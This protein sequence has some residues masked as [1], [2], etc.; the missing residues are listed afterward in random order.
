MLQFQQDAAISAGNG[1]ADYE[2]IFSVFDEDNSHCLSRRELKRG[3]K[4][5]KVEISRDEFRAVCEHF[6]K[7]GDGDI[8]Y[9]EF[10]AFC[11]G[12]GGGASSPTRSKRTSKRADSEA[13]PADKE[14]SARE[15]R[16][17]ARKAAD[18]EASKA[19][20][21]R[22]ADRDAAKKRSMT[23][24]ERR[25]ADALSTAEVNELAQSVR[26][27]V[28]QAVRST[29]S[30][31]VDVFAKFDPEDKGYVTL[32]DLKSSL[33]E[34]GF[35][36]DK[37]TL[38]QLSL[39]FDKDGDGLVSIGEFYEFVSS[40]AHSSRRPTSR[41]TSGRSGI[42]EA[43]GAVDPTED[44]TGMGQAEVTKRLI[45]ELWREVRSRQ[46]S[47]KM[48]IDEAYRAL[49]LKGSGPR[50][51]TTASLKMNA[52]ELN[53]AIPSLEVAGRLVRKIG[54]RSYRDESSD[55]ADGKSED[56]F[57]VKESD[58][59]AF[60]NNPQ[61]KQ[62]EQQLRLAILQLVAVDSGKSAAEASVSGSRRKSRSQRHRISD[63]VPQRFADAFEESDPDYTGIVA[64]VEFRKICKAMK[65]DLSSQMLKSITQRYVSIHSSP[66][67]AQVCAFMGGFLSQTPQCCKNCP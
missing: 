49:A 38:H 34:L 28:N 52:S 42:S 31:I 17:E 62:L 29:G 58:F 50:V 54:S 12:K 67:H 7:D 57:V 64:P 14:T 9:D 11:V 59:A 20:V 1:T 18:S 24:S 32:T 16:L 33:R 26:K 25:E 5:I 39:R 15:A 65:L 45:A 27:A 53:V 40:S 23:A 55:A 2:A 10:R 44:Q 30:T 19:E 8:D 56:Q 21:K 61:F 47:K 35:D 63:G 43:A 51:I 13:S 22:V 36:A 41:T 4:K 48:T 60:L 3:L 46:R 37:A 6:D 66:H